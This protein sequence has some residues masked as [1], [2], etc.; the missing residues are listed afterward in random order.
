MGISNS[1]YQ[2][3]FTEMYPTRSPY[4]QHDEGYMIIKAYTDAAKD[5]FYLSIKNPNYKKIYNMLQKNNVYRFITNT[6][7]SHEL[8]DVK[9][10]LIYMATIKITDLL[11]LSKQYANGYNCHQVLHECESGY[12]PIYEPDDN[13]KIE[14]I[15]EAVKL[16][17]IIDNDSIG[18]LHIGSIYNVK[19]KKHY[20]SNLYHVFEYERIHVDGLNINH[21]EKVKLL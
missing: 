7:L 14:E 19:F 17:L 6:M 21:E 20:F 11:D 4:G 13:D 3:V 8:L 5:T 12:N 1:V 9:E 16:K 15:H 18:N 2:V 10:E